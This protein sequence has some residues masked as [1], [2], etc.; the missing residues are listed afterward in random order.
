MQRNCLRKVVG[1][2]CFLLLVLAAHAQKYTVTGGQG[3]PLLATTVD[4][5]QVYLVYGM[6]NVEIRYT[7]VA[8]NHKWYKYKNKAL[9]DGVEI[10]SFMEGATT[11]VRNIE[12]GYGY[13]VM[14]ND[15]I[16]TAKYVWIIDYSK[17][18]FDI[19]SFH[20]DTE[21]S[22]C[23]G[24]YLATSG[25]VKDIKYSRPKGVPGTLEREFEV[26]YQTMDYE[27]NSSMM[28]TKTVTE[29]INDPFKDKI[30]PPFCDTDVTLSGDL[31]ARHFGVGKTITSDVYQAVA[32]KATMKI[33]TLSYASDIPNMVVKGDSLSAPVEFNFTAIANIPVAAVF[34]WSI[35]QKNEGTENT[36]LL[37]QNGNR[38][39]INYT[40]NRNGT[41]IVSLEV[42]DR[43][44]QCTDILPEV[45]INI[46]DT[47]LEVPNAFSP[48]TTPGINDEFRVAYRSLN[49]FKCWIF[50]RWGAEI[51]HWT[52]PS[53]GWDGKKGGKYVAPGVYF[54]VIEATGSDGK[55]IKKKGSINILRSKRIDDE[56]IEE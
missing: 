31:F 19:S 4:D 21:K 45:T 28:V 26:T 35:F 33:D 23:D 55:R 17:Y 51:Y 13:Y 20:V 41:Y 50:N 37:E 8:G 24:M 44:L 25:E 34:K 52:D 11:V 30:G 9:G 5:L 32:V 46:S 56:I 42:S 38:E 22:N 53:Q 48:G 2:L 36:K 18:A 39:E 54:Y 12:E 47:Y 49:S 6:E 14:E 10:P 43:T 27:E 7:P 29:T 1:T 40:F 15:N 16:A 3:T